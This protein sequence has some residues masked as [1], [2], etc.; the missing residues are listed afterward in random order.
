M[1]D[2]GCRGAWKGGAMGKDA[3]RRGAGN[4]K[5][6]TQSG[7]AVARGAA[8]GLSQPQQS[9]VYKAGAKKRARAKRLIAQA[10]RPR[11]KNAHSA[12]KDIF[13]VA[14]QFG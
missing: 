8:H 2:R 12:D 13:E 6:T 1:G 10:R 7:A 4:Q 11:I 3:G 9:A 5:G 14:P